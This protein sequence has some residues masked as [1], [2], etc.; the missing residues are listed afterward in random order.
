MPMEYS[1]NSEEKTSGWMQMVAVVVF[2]VSFGEDELVEDEKNISRHRFDLDDEKLE[3]KV[4]VFSKAARC[5]Y[6]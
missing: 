4:G 5:W 3:A 2:A 6:L 1:R